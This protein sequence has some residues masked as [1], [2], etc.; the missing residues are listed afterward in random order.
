VAESRLV[1]K[2]SFDASEMILGLRRAAEALE[3]A[4]ARPEPRPEAIEDVLDA[5]EDMVTQHCHQT[6]EWY[7]TG[8]LSANRH[9]MDVLVAAGRAEFIGEPYGRM[10]T[11]RLHPPV[12]RAVVDVPGPDDLEVLDPDCRA[13]KHGS[14]VGGPCTC[15]CHEVHRA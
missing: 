3:A 14:C 15:S 2:A 10:A 7:D 8:A 11:I 4:Q 1:I 6:G 5:L 12:E 13:D 9:A